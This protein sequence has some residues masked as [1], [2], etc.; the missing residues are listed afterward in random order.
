MTR[1]NRGLKPGI[2][3]ENRGAAGACRGVGCGFG[4]RKDPPGPGWGAGVRKKPPGPGWGAGR[5]WG[6]P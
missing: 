1:G 6:L 4:M 2:W 5:A 3:G